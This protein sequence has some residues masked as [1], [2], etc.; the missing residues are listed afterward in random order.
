MPRRAL[1]MIGNTAGRELA[2]P[3]NREEKTMTTEQRLENDIRHTIAR[4]YGPLTRQASDVVSFFALAL[5][6]ASV[7]LFSDLIIR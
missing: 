2:F 5:F 6:I 7:W 1:G 4:H 3:F